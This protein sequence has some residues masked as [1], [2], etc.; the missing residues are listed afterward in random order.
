M[1][2]QR[3]GSRG[4][5]GLTLSLGGGPELEREADDGEAHAGQVQG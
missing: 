4:P 3:K 5:A 1:S 2:G